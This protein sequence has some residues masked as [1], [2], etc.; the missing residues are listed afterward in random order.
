MGLLIVG[1]VAV[2]ATVTAL[3]L[4]LAATYE[5]GFY[6][7]AMEVDPAVLEK[8]S[9]QMLQQAAALAS[10]VRKDPHWETLI[11][12]EQINGWLAVDMVKNHPNALPAMLRDP[13]VVI[14]SKRITIA[15]RL[16]QDGI[17]SVLSLTVEPYMP[18]PNVVAL[19]IVKARA[20]LLPA[21]L[22]KVLDGVKRAAREMQLHLEWLRTGDDPVAL[23]SLPPSD[24]RPVSIETLRLGD[25]EI[26]VEG[27]TSKKKP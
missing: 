20:G 1:G 9:D 2:L 25:G 18:K 27:S 24:E 3:G 16:E 14:D 7:E 15:C 19:R 10:A 22:G 8:G 13:R 5:P 23:L 4:F 11:T 12:A 6:C 17:H 21:P 26:Y